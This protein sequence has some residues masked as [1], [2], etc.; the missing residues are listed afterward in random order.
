MR[1][2]S[3]SSDSVLGPIVATIFVDFLGFILSKLHYNALLIKLW[4]DACMSP[5]LRIG[6]PITAILVILGT[7]SYFFYTQY[8]TLQATRI[9]LAN[10]S[11]E[12]AKLKASLATT[13]EARE[14]LAST[15]YAEQH[16]NQVFQ[17]QISDIGSTV[18]KL[19]KLA[20]TDP[21]LLAKYSKVYFLN[22]N[23]IPSELT[24]I[25]TKYLFEL[26]RKFQ[27]HTEV[28]PHLYAMLDAAA[29]DGID[30]KIIS[31]YRSFSTQASLKVSYKF[32]YGAGTANAFS[33]DQGYSEH[34]LGTA[35]DFTTTKVGSSFAGFDKTDA[36]TWL[37]KHAHQYGFILSYPKSNKYY[38]YEPWHWRFVGTA[39]AIKLHADDQ[40]FYDLD[41]REINTYLINLFD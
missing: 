19:D 11:A 12:A 6:L 29:E 1:R 38:T 3:I 27:I 40:V 33:A 32:T 21:Q 4:Q 2:E 24:D 8:Q 35:L 7:G 18:G 41:Q 20:K 15:L 23:Y 14:V 37:T 30:L 34:Q 25:D 10:T 16:K 5:L 17:S 28:Q 31:A 36:Y 13:T 39:L 9:E 26:S 22:E